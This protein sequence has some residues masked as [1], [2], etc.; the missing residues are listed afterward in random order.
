MRVIRIFL[1]TPSDVEEERVHVANLIRDIN[2][3]VQF[4]APTQDVR[5]ELV[6]YETHAFPD[7]GAPQEVIDRQIPVDYDLYL[8]IMWR[9]AGTP[10]ADAMSGTI[11]EFDNALAH[12]GLR[13][14]PVIMFFF[15]DEKLD[16]PQLDEEIEQLQQVLDFRR[17]LSSIGLTVS[18]ATHEAFR[19]AAR[20]RLLRGLADILFAPKRED[21]R[22]GTHEPSVPSAQ[23]KAL[24]DTAQLYDETRRVM[25]SGI[26]RTREMT[27]I[28]NS[29][30]ELAAACRPLVADLEKSPS[31]G[32]RLA[33]IAILYAFPET[34]HLEWLAERLDNPHVESPFVG[35]QASV[36]LGQAARSLPAR[37]ISAVKTALNRALDLAKKLPEDPDRIRA[38]E[39]A[40]HEAS[41]RSPKRQT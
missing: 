35:Y 2:E 32:E 30:V 39:Y 18:Y 34:D 21:L 33:A 27:K 31:S 25:K 14:W 24:R 22:V 17:R 40:V 37:D 16:F 1:S 10:T 6:Q 23:E 19:D 7:V 5:L 38:L 13:G 8:G 29:M 4:L 28:F 3:T 11:H 20:A 12:R 41:L 15:C 9:R 36:A 26:A